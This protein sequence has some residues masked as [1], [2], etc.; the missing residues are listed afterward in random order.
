[1][2]VVKFKYSSYRW[3]REDDSRA[4]NPE[5]E[6]FIYEMLKDTS[7]T[8]TVGFW[9]W[10]EDGSY[11]LEFLE[12]AGEYIEV[13]TSIDPVEVAAE[14]KQRLLHLGSLY[15]VAIEAIA[16]MK[17]GALMPHFELL[18]EIYW[19]PPTLPPYPGWEQSLASYEQKL[20]EMMSL[21][22]LVEEEFVQPS[23]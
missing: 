16:R 15:A 1:M 8:I 22:L 3:A 17:W 19:Q 18:P 10:W 7:F 5:F 12:E 4:M 20:A 21:P 11:S 14:F 23:P 9:R 13:D 2:F 6:H